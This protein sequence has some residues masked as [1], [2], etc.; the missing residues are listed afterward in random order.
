M[1]EHNLNLQQNY[2]KMRYHKRDSCYR[3]YRHHRCHTIRSVIV[4]LSCLG[5]RFVYKRASFTKC[6]GQ[7]LR[8]RKFKI[9]CRIYCGDVVLHTARHGTDGRQSGEND[10]ERCGLPDGTGQHSTDGR[11]GVRQHPAPP[12]EHARQGAAG[13]QRHFRCIGSGKDKWL[14]DR[15]S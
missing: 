10:P 14:N 4:S 5:H 3:K 12:G 9:I 13:R 2:L 1:G 7:V 15:F 11:A 8:N 6:V